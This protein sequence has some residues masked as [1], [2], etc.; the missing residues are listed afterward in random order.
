MTSLTTA[1]KAL[2]EVHDA[3]MKAQSVSEFINQTD[4]FTDRA[5]VFIRDHGQEILDMIEKERK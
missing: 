3:I 4:V 5:N 1:L 2:I